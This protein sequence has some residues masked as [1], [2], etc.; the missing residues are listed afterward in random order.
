M[1][2]IVYIPPQVFFRIA[3]IRVDLKI[4]KKNQFRVAG[5]GFRVVS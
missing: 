4:P 5:F 2:S 1:I 3:K